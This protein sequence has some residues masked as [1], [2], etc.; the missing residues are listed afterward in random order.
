MQFYGITGLAHKWFSSY[1][2]NRKQYCRV[3]GTTSSIENIDIGV[4]QASC[5][6]PLLF[7]LYIN[8]LPFALA[9]HRAKA[10]VYADDTAISYSSDKSEELD[11]VINEE[12]SYIEKWLQGNKFSLNVFKTQAM[13]IGSQPK[14]EKLKNNLSSLP[15]FKVGGEEINLV[16]ETKYLG[17]MID[18]CLESHIN[19]VQ[20]KISRAIDL[21]KYERNFVQTDT[22]I[23]LYRSITE[24]HFRYCC[25]VWGSCGASELDV[26]QELQNKAARIV[27]NSPFD[28]S[29]AP[30]LQRL[31]W[32]SVHKLINKETCSMVYRSLNSLAPQYLSDLFV[33]L[34]EVHP[35]E[36]RISKTNLAIP[37]L[38]TGN[39]QK[40]FAYRG[41]SLWNSL[42]LDTKM[43]PSINA[44]KSKL[45]EK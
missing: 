34:S 11:L 14:I 32:P 24:P 31:G 44:F 26:L 41:A 45:K 8:D 1:L 21:L 33:R 29:A 38:R 15:S 37:M 39:G 36:L 5:L 10:T 16:N 40:S 7:L 25:S 3:N 4:P 28:A 23:N 22:L 20:K 12:L 27:A 19:A 30:L 42:D 2:D 35:R 17:V 9:L 13:I 6:G 18:N 43:A